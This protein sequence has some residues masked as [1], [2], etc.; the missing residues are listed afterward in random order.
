MLIC[1]KLYIWIGYGVTK[2]IFTPINRFN[3]KK[4]VSAKIITDFG[5]QHLISTG[6]IL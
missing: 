5:K 3:D 2:C 6:S 1:E 4:I